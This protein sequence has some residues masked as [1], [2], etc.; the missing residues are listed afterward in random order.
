MGKMATKPEGLL[1]DLTLPDQLD[2]L[3]ERI[4]ARLSEG[5]AHAV[6]DRICLDV[7]RNDALYVLR[8]AC[9]KHPAAGW[10]IALSQK[11]EKP[12]GRIHLEETRE[13]SF[14]SGVCSAH[15]RAGH[16]EALVAAGVYGPQPAAA[17]LASGWVSAAVQAGAR[18]IETNPDAKLVAAFE[19][20]AEEDLD[21]VLCQLLP[22]LRSKRAARAL[23]ADLARY[24]RASS[25]LAAV[26]PGL[27]GA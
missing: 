23:T 4:A 8:V 14:F 19:A 22:R 7:G 20:I 12:A 18:C 15:A 24:P 9:R 26:L 10:L 16:V 27:A 2:E 13:L 3:A 5:P 11:W 21:A 6:Y 25:T 17:L 1:A